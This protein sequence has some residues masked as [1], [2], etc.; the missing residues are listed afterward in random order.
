MIP[1]NSASDFELPSRGLR[2]LSWPIDETRRCWSSWAGWTRCSS[3]NENSLHA[4]FEVQGSGKVVGVDVRVE[5]P[6]KRQP[7]LGQNLQVPVDGVDHG[8]DQQHLPGL[9]AVDEIGV[10]A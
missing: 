3:G 7:A 9:L 5:R 1:A 10:C 2:A 6:C 8:V 4:L